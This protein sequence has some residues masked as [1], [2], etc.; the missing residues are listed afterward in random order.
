MDVNIGE[1]IIECQPGE[2]YFIEGN[3]KHL[4]KAAEDEDL[5]FVF[6]F[7]YDPFDEIEYHHHVDYSNAWAVP[8]KPPSNPLVTLVISLYWS[9][10]SFR[11]SSLF[12]D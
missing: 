6:F 11:M 4:T 7:P 5:I 12:G 2:M 9:D 1:N 10:K 8:R 3:T